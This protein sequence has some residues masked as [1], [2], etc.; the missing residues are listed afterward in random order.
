MAAVGIAFVSLAA[1]QDKQADPSVE[2]LQKIPS[3]TSRPLDGTH[4]LGT[5]E[6]PAAGVPNLAEVIPAAGVLSGRLRVL[7]DM[8]EI[9]VD[10]SAA[11]DKYGEIEARLKDHDA[12]LARLQESSDY[13]YTR[14][15]DLKKVIRQ[16]RELL[17]EVSKPLDAAILQ[18]SSQQQEWLAEE[19]RW[20][21]WQASF[22][23][24]LESEQLNATF[25]QASQTI[26]VALDLIHPRLEAVLTA[27]SNGAG[28]YTEIHVLTEALEALIL[29]QSRV[30]LVFDSPPMFSAEYLRQIKTD[31]SHAI[32]EGISQITWLDE[33]FLTR[34]GWILLVQV[35]LS[36]FIALAINGSRNALNQSERWRFLAARPVSAGLFSGFMITVA[37]YEY[38]GAPSLWNL[39]NA[40]VGTCSFARLAQGILEASWKRRIVYAVMILLIATMLVNLISF[41]LPLFRLYVVLAACV[42]FGLL[43]RW[44]RESQRKR[45]SH[46]YPWLLRL[47]AL[48]LVGVTIA[49]FWGNDA[50]ARH[51]FESTLDSLATT[52]VFVLFAY[53]LNGGMEWLLKTLL[54]SR[55]T[56][57]KGLD[58]TAD[59]RRATHLIG[60]LIGVL[61]WLPATLMI[62]GVY[63]N[64][65]DAMRGVLVFGVTI[66]SQR[67]EL[68][69]LIFSVSIFY[70]SFLVSGILQR[71][72]NEKVFLRREMARGLRFS[73]SRLVHY[74]VTSVGF[75]LAI[76]YLG[77]DVTKLTIMLS[78]L[79]VGIGFGLQSV[80]NNFV[81]GLILLFE[82]P[83]RVG[84]TVEVGGGWAEIKNI[85]L[86]ATC[87]QTFD[88]ADIII[89]NA[90]LINN[91][92]TNWTL[93]SRK[94]RLI[95]P[96][97]VAYGSNVPLVMETLT[98]CAK[99]NAMVVD[100][101]SPQV[102]FQSFGE[103]SLDFELRVWVKD[104]DHRLMVRSELHQ[105]IDRLFRDAQIE[106]TFP[107]R[108]LHLRS[109]DASVVLPKSERSE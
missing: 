83:V 62:W 54:S 2:G 100:F 21:Q 20:G 61:V 59:V 77:F 12:R 88:Q 82:R 43:L 9:G 32:R 76:S 105:E 51:L 64:F 65:Q 33:R 71:L 97:G 1:A 73:I 79:G 26:N 47:G 45:E 15:L 69:L 55:E 56:G 66:G 44:A 89:P 10:V 80:V 48:F 52:F 14:L 102:L 63:D 13:R 34:Q 19:A 68:G 60:F 6:T 50:L 4:E 107:Q 30:A 109:V 93:S 70:G 95:I 78:A 85:G 16:E 57:R 5:E 86:R 98:A 36:I 101:P 38:A 39:G 75:I 23:R 41:P 67:I 37:L 22:D 99:A 17:D 35:T 74:I 72:L 8:V 81:S 29:D 104:A 87:I 42:G 53:M 25:A 31:H 96:V 91:P 106:I 27:Q 90:D 24:E 84:D 46:F 94:V 18:L 103:S 92:V 49:E 11:T 28:V 108:D 3:E 40:I 7:R 58:V